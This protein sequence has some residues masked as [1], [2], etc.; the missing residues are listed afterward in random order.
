MIKIISF[1][2]QL[3]YERLT[4]V[5]M[6]SDTTFYDRID[7]TY[8]FIKLFLDKT[9]FIFMAYGAFNDQCFNDTLT[10]L[11]VSFEQLGPDVFYFLFFYANICCVVLVRNASWRNK[12][13]VNIFR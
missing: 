9:M 10:N 8:Q 11:I 2:I 4:E 5:Y 6:L 7:T 1:L 12:K 13:N 3:K